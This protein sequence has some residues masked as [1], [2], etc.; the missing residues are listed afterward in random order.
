VK[1]A[2]A[3]LAA[4]SFAALAMPASAQQEDETQGNAIQSAAPAEPLPSDE[5][6]DSVF[7][8]TWLGV[9]LGARVDT[10]YDGSDD[11]VIYPLPAAVGKIA[12]VGFS[13][14]AAGIALDLVE[15]ELGDDV[16]FSAGPVARLRQN[17]VRNIKDPV[18]EA[19]GEL[20]T[21]IEVGVT[22][23]LTFKGILNEYDRFSIGTDLRWDVNGAHGGFII[24]P[25][26]SYRTPLSKG[27][28]LGATAGAQYADTD[29]NDYYFSV[30]P[31]QSAASGLPI[32]LADKGW[33]KA[34]GS[35][36]V[37]FD[38]DGDIENGG[39]IVGALVGYSRML[40]DARRTPYTSLRGSADQFYA[41]T[42][43]GYIF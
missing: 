29:F 23:G 36:A 15:V 13:P 30:S 34:G 42:G 31:A 24:D 19:A 26:I 18:V 17:R 40:G 21:A 3:G 27:I 14:R 22:V 37:G 11:Y 4:L 9:G 41:A 43:V 25:G 8:D 5:G 33:Y 32:Y 10:S 35:L 1:R 12:G 39:F 7:D 28:V 38:L 2:C 20:D 6:T 16:E